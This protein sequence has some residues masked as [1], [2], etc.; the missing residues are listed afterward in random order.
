LKRQGVY[1]HNKLESNG[2]ILE[3]SFSTS[4][5]TKKQDR[6]KIWDPCLFMGKSLKDAAKILCIKTQKG[7][8]DHKKMISWSDV[9]KYCDEVKEYL[10]K[11]VECVYQ[12]AETF[13]SKFYKKL[14]ANV[15]K[16]LTIG[17]AAF[18]TNQSFLK[19][20]T[21]Q[22]ELFREEI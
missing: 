7:D 6:T 14:N 10:I 15:F 13:N 4:K 3:L 20:Q 8:F 11:D 19:P 21:K 2:R 5:D 1:I 18:K 16:F 22:I 9:D 12:I 17:Q